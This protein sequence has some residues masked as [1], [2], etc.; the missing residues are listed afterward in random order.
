MRRLCALGVL[1]IAALSGS[2]FGQ[3]LQAGTLTKLKDATA[4]VKWTKGREL[5]MGSAFLVRKTADTGW[6]LTCAHVVDGTGKAQLVLA[7]GSGKERVLEGEVIGIDADRDVACLRVKDASLPAVLDLAPK[8][9][10]RETENV[11]VAGFPFGEM[12]ATSSKNPDI[13]ISKVSVSSIRKDDDGKI[14]IVQLDGNVN[15]GNSGGPVVDAKGRVV[16]MAAAKITGTGLNF[17][18]PPES[19][20]AFLGGRVNSVTFTPAESDAKKARLDVGATLIDP[21]G[22]LKNVSFAWVRRSAVKGD[23]ARGADG[24][25]KAVSPL[26]KDVTMKPAADGATA[27]G[28][29][30]ITRAP[31]DPE[32]LVIMFQVHWTLEDGTVV[33]T[34]PDTQTVAFAAAAPTPPGPAPGPGTPDKPQP[35]PAP[36]AE[37][38]IG[39]ELREVARL[40]LMSVVGEIFLS[41]DASYLYVLDLSDSKLLKVRASDLGIETELAFEDAV[42]CAHF[43][44]ASGTIYVGVRGEPGNAYGARGSGRVTAVPVATWKAGASVD[45]EGDPVD[46]AVT[47]SGMAVVSVIGQFRGAV[48]VDLK[49]KTAEV[50]EQL[51]GGCSLGLHP[52]QTRAYFGKIEGSPGEFYCLPLQ[53]DSTGRFVSYDSPYHGDYPLGGEFEITPDGKFLMSAVGSVLRLGKGREADMKYVAKTD[54]WLCAAVAPGC[55]TAF[56]ATPEGFV[57]DVALGSFELRKSLRVSGVCTRMVLDPAR[58]MLFAHVSGAPKERTGGRYY[59]GRRQLLAGDLVAWSLEAK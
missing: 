52:D 41:K 21:M 38:A 6:F 53:R 19:L 13:S 17:A 18:V 42:T 54:P 57:K 50:I 26:C 4:Y 14:A 25:W 55:G 12:L 3:E 7:S 51:N 27:R 36:G 28:T 43:D 1:A 15:P 9:E 33:W 10:L 32:Q 49:K 31:D 56:L 34:Q 2:A 20:K 39:D 35:L 29:L 37:L 23:P 40:S 58:K 5:R 22:A 47:G 59:P 8:T 11:F 48:V 44:A 46:L 24:K 30:E 45:F 16:G